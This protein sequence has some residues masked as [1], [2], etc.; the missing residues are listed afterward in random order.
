MTFRK[1]HAFGLGAIFAGIVAGVLVLLAPSRKIAPEPHLP[2]A[3][4]LTDSARASL[5]SEM[6]AHARAAL[7]LVSTVTVLDWQGSAAVA[8]ELLA[9]PRI[10]AATATALPLR[11]FALQD[12]LRRHVEAVDR[13]A[14][15][16]DADALADAFAAAAKTCV[17]CHDAYVTGR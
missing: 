3:E 5:K 10:A 12:E 7:Q 4:R 11:F 9:E 2:V 16:H 14:K 13:A 8:E 1:L 15:A 6:H 17:H